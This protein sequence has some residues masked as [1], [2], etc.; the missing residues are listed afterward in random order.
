MKGRPCL[1]AV[2]FSRLLITWLSGRRLKNIKG[3]LERKDCRKGSVKLN[4]CGQPSIRHR[5]RDNAQEL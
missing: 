3:A 2:V 5:I 4:K 1:D